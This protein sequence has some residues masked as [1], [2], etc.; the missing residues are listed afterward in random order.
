M[1]LYIY[2]C[3]CLYTYKKPLCLKICTSFHSLH[4]FNFLLKEKIFV[5]ITYLQIFKKDFRLILC[6]LFSS[7]TMQ[8]AEIHYNREQEC[9][10]GTDIITRGVRIWT[11]NLLRVRLPQTALLQIQ[12]MYCQKTIQSISY[13]RCL[14]HSNSL[15]LLSSHLRSCISGQF[16]LFG[17]TCISKIRCMTEWRIYSILHWLQW[18]KD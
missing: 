15:Y 8:H 12:P 5:W 4:I 1:H 18:L 10:T 16:N 2:I 7:I 3:T 14:Y 11:W 17:H 9:P 6:G 13:Y